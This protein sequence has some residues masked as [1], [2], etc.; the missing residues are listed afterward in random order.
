MTKSALRAPPAS[1]PSS[2]RTPP[3]SGVEGIVKHL[4]RRAVIGAVVVGA[5]V[6]V[7]A[8][9]GSSSSATSPKTACGK[10]DLGPLAGN[11]RLTKATG[12]RLGDARTALAKEQRTTPKAWASLAAST[13]V[14]LCVYDIR[15]TDGSAVG[16]ACADNKGLATM[17]NIAYLANPDAPTA[18][19]SMMVPFISITNGKP[20]VFDDMQKQCAA[21]SG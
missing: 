12:W 7:L 5:L 16:L 1:K 6:V 9:C 4:V 18:P 21:A 8:A 3:S 14:A 15:D 19:H 2:R 20:V 11:A 13:P 10:V 17:K